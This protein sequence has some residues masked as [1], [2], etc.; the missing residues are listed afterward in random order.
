M[1]LVYKNFLS[2][3]LIFSFNPVYGGSECRSFLNDQNNRTLQYFTSNLRIKILET[4]DEI[5]A[6]LDVVN[7]KQ[8]EEQSKDRIPRE[9]M[10]SHII[11]GQSNLADAREAFFNDDKVLGISFGIFLNDKVIGFITFSEYYKDLLTSIRNQT[12]LEGENWLVYGIAILPEFQGRGYGKEV[13]NWRLK[14]AFESLGADGVFVD[15]KPS[16]SISQSLSRQFGF[17]PLYLVM[18]DGGD[19][20]YLSRSQ[21]LRQ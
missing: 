16:N 4:D 2:L 19:I 12:N 20:F 10:L 17:Q 5:N 18:P 21:Y 3:L 6:A 1:N 11:N 14:F 13:T 9:E 15:I 8:V 7:N